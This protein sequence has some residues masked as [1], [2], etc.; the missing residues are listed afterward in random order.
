MK[1]KQLINLGLILAV[2]SALVVVKQMQKP[3]ELATQEYT[4]LDLAFDDAK[5]AG[6][7]IIKPQGK[8][9][10]YADV[11]KIGE[12]WKVKS[13]LNARADKSK[14]EEF[15]KELKAAKGE[16]RAK[17]KTLLKDFGIADDQ[18]YQVTL[19]GA[20][21]K[22]LLD[23]RIATKKA[24]R[25]IFIRRTGSDAIFMTPADVFGK[26]GVYGDPATEQ[27]NNSFWADTS[28]VDVSPDKVE[29]IEITHY[30]KNKAMLHGGVIRQ[31]SPKDASKKE[32]HFLREGIPF[33]PDAVK[34]KSFLDSF[35]SWRASAVLEPD[36]NK[37]YGF[38]KQEWTMTLRLE[39][40]QI[41]TINAGTTEQEKHLTYMRVSSEPVVFQMASYFY[42]N[43]DADD[44]RFFS[45]NPFEMDAAKTK[46][47]I[48]NA[49][50][51][52]WEVHPK[53]K[54]WDDL[55]KYLE[56]LKT[57]NISRVLLQGD[58]L[59]KA[60]SPSRFFIEILKEGAVAPTILD[61]GE[62]VKDSP[63]EYALT[64]RGNHQPLAVSD[65]FYKKFF[66]E[67]TRLDAPKQAEVES[68]K[69][70]VGIKA[71]KP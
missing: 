64:L 12:A 4:S 8:D 47:L 61:F 25:S 50:K 39:G 23:L 21:Q 45:D 2:I 16:L 56:D 37:D 19:K 40:D 57:M 54:T 59:K 69:S 24:G 46:S 7:S 60:K 11:V 65:Y 41:I 9:E 48:V 13:I 20:D 3:K 33:L 30:Q 42:E 31:L 44:S 32:W 34:I 36:K 55:G 27:I 26:M 22:I 15:L 1:T 67:T 68:K 52:R 70:E 51:K 63:K 10:Q 62:E 43:L 17:D 18:A 5:I 6:V 29:G 66:E 49:D 38:G 58:E 14:I 35:K 71:A 28:L 53:E